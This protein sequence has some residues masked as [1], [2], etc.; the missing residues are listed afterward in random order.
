M[1][2]NRSTKTAIFL[3]L[4]WAALLVPKELFACDLLEGKVQSTCCCETAATGC[5]QGGN[6]KG[7]DTKA[8]AACCDIS[9]ATTAT[10]TADDSKNFQATEPKY[11][12]V[13]ALPPD[14]LSLA[15][16]PN[17]ARPLP[18]VFRFLPSGKQ[19]YLTTARFRE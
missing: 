9:Y 10:A 2:V 17:W 13:T 1:S 7:H 11:P 5:E 8:V 18:P 4:A 15:I 12:E 14:T 19:L 6:C 16:K 3:L